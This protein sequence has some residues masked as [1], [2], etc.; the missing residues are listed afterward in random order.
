MIEVGIK[1][2]DFKLSDQNK[3]I[4]RLS[5]LHGKRVLLSFR[6]LAWTPVCTDQM[7][8]LDKHYGD[9]ENFNAMPLGIG[10]DS[11]YSNKAWAEAMEIKKLRLLADFWPHGQVA[12]S[13]G[14]FRAEGGFSERA[15]ILINEMQQVIFAKVYEI[16][17]L[18]DIE[19]VLDLLSKQQFT[20]K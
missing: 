13:Y 15:N 16:S 1:A 14:I 4:I 18:P 3:K 2:P 6:P 20:V 12:S 17:E 7:T 8:S 9:F 5:K 11:V 19:E 10:V